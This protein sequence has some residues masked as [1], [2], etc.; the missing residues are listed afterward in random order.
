[1]GTQIDGRKTCEI[2][3]MIVYRLAALAHFRI[4]Y[5]YV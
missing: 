5:L 3:E 2:K 4:K 1:M